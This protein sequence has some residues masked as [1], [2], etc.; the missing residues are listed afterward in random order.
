[1]CFGHGSISNWSARRELHSRSPRPKRGMFLLH[2]ALFAPAMFREGAGVLFLVEDGEHGPWTRTPP[3]G[4]CIRPPTLSV[5]L[6]P[7]WPCASTFP[8][9]T[10]C[11]SLQ[12]PVKKCPTRTGLQVAFKCNC[13]ILILECG[14][15]SDHPRAILRSV[16]D[17]SGIVGL[18][19]ILQ[20]LGLACVNLLRLRMRLQRIH[21]VKT[22]H[23]D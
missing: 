17:F 23:D 15:R 9:T 5:D 7:W 20:V 16:W 19:S 14:R 10:G 1:M 12:M 6:H 18:Q 21:V 8:Q 2:H 13:P 11:R 22:V 3:E 4:I